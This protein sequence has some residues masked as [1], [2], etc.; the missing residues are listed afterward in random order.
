[1]NVKGIKLIVNSVNSILRMK[2]FFLWLWWGPCNLGKAR[3]GIK[4]TA[5]KINKKDDQT[6]LEERDEKGQWGEDPVYSVYHVTHVWKAPFCAHDRALSTR[7]WDVFLSS[8]P[9]DILWPF[10]FFFKIVVPPFLLPLL[11][12]LLVSLLC[13]RFSGLPCYIPVSVSSLFFISLFVSFPFSFP[14]FLS[15]LGLSSKKF[16]ALFNSAKMQLRIRW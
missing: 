16:I 10:A 11:F 13:Y 2:A 9:F 1:M 8:L 14:V 6:E 7:I 5:E 15:F 12:S 4:R 3:P